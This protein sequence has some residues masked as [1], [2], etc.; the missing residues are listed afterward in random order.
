MIVD[1]ASYSGGQRRPCADFSDELAARRAEDDGFIW[2]GMKEP[3]Y[4]EFERVADELGL[5]PLAVEDAVTGHQRPKLDVY[6]RSAFLVLKTLRYIEATSDVETGEIMV[7]L[8]DRFVVTVRRGEG[9]PLT[10]VRRDIEESPEQL[11]HGP[12]AVLYAVMDAVVDGYTRIEGELQDDLDRIE[13]DVFAGDRGTDAATIYRLK[14]EVL[15]FKRAAQPLLEPAR[16]LARDEVAYV[17]PSARPF[18]ADIL[19]HLARVV[20]HVESYD[21]LLTDVLSAHLAQVSVQ[22]NADMRKISAWVA[23]A[24]VPTMLAGIWGMNFEHM[25]ELPQVWGYPAALALMVTVSGLLYATFRRTGW[26]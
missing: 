6:K 12:G 13:A 7:F 22:Q 1:V 11:A 16:R 4:E 14:R 20:D 24:A 23:I 10:N 5:H 21:R 9:V 18:F 25:P 17:A 3:T 19:D 8:G 15:E 26:L 2:I